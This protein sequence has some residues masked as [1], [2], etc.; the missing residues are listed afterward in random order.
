VTGAIVAK[1]Q[2]DA[3]GRV[4][5]ASVAISRSALAAIRRPNVLPE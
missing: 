5:H 3:H 1:E 4:D 2:E